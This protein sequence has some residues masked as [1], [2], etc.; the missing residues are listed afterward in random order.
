MK[1]TESEMNTELSLECYKQIVE[2]A[3]EAIIMIQENRIIYHNL[4]AVRI[5]GYSSE[6]LFA[7]PFMQFIHPEDKSMVK[8]NYEQDL[9]DLH[10]MSTCTFRIVTKNRKVRWIQ[11]RSMS[12]DCDGKPAILNW[13]KDIT[14]QRD[15]ERRIENALLEKTWGLQSIHKTVKSNLYTLSSL[16]SMQTHSSYHRDKDEILHQ[17][18]N[19][20]LSF[21]KIHDYLAQSD[22]Y[23]TINLKDYFQ[24][25][26]QVLLHAS[27][28]TLQDMDMKI[29]GPDLDVS[30][31]QAIPCG[32]IL[33]ELVT[34]TIQHAFPAEWKNKKQIEITLQKKKQE[35]ILKFQDN[36]IGLPFTRN[37]QEIESLGLQ[38]VMLIVEDQLKGRLHYSQD[39]GTAFTIIFKEEPTCKK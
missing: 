10:E 13:M 36:G 27:Y 29:L 7:T 9:Y 28:H 20:I 19:R 22:K 2:Q 26:T 8:Y 4:M 16:I 30:I 3:V 32:I 12:I 1:K 37:I 18:R 39:S 17:A 14:K 5:S 25:L 21:A 38:F 6:E 33:N 11:K 34:N 15:L 35:I 24:D 23:T 31:S